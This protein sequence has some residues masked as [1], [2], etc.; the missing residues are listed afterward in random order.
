MCAGLLTWGTKV[1]DE[2]CSVG[3]DVMYSA[4]HRRK[5]NPY[6]VGD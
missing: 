5:V 1:A 4:E 2:P 3:Q 6:G